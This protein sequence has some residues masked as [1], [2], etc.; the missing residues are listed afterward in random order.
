[1]FSNVITK[2]E[3]WTKE[4][5]FT[6]ELNKIINLKYNLEDQVMLATLYMLLFNRIELIKSEDQDRKIALTAKL[7]YDFEDLLLEKD[8]LKLICYNQFDFDKAKAIEY[9]KEHHPDATELIDVELFMEKHAE[10]VVFIKKEDNAAIILMK[11]ISRKK[12]HLLS[13]LLPRFLPQFF[14]RFPLSATEVEI[15]K[16]LTF[17]SPVKYLNL[18]SNRANDWDIKKR[19]NRATIEIFRKSANEALLKE[20]LY[21]LNC[22]RREIERIENEYREMIRQ[23]DRE[24]AT[25]EGRKYAAEHSQTDDALINYI[26]NNRHINIISANDTV[27]KMYITSC[28]DNFNPDMYENYAKRGDIFERY[29]DCLINTVEDRKLLLNSIFSEEPSLKLRVVSYIVLDTRGSVSSATN[30]DYKLYKDRLPNPHL[31]IFNCFGDNKRFIQKALR[32]N[33]LI[34][35]IEQCTAVVRNLNL[36]EVSQTVRPFF[37]WIFNSTEKIIEKFDGTQMTPKEA[38]AWLKAEKENAEK[39]NDN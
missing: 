39:E 4:E 9:I 35:A 27:L 6:N 31:Q 34:L 30:H 21:N 23:L 12:I 32:E 25:Y 8:S 37:S 36:S 20:D 3:P 14:E 26:E 16:S 18:M 7:F 28:I 13:S 24:T 11:E 22:T 38:I 5:S 33:N 1:M 29:P 10:T 17:T 15:L 19:I 2:V